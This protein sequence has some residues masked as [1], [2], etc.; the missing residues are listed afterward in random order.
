M[1][2]G[3]VLKSEEYLQAKNRIDEFRGRAEEMGQ[4]DGLL[5]LYREIEGFFSLMQEKRPHMYSLFE[6]DEKELAGLIRKKLTGEDA[7]ID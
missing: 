6:I 2:I 7:I 1:D 5:E 4:E 3:E